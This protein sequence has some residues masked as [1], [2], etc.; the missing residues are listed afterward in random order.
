MDSMVDDTH[1]MIMTVDGQPSGEYEN[2]ILKD[3][4]DIVIEYKEKI[5]QPTNNETQ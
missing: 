3:K 5:A 1:E 2:L 4:Q